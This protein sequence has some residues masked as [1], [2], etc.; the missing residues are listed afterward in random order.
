QAFTQTATDCEQN[1]TR[2]RVEKYVD[3]KSGATVQV[4]STSESR[5]ITGQTSTRSATGTKATKVCE[6]SSVTQWIVIPLP[7]PNHRINVYWNGENL[8]TNRD[9][10]LTMFRLNGY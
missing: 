3:H 8:Y 4:S 10:T 2:S 7:S 5:T 1:Q 6:Y 9:Y